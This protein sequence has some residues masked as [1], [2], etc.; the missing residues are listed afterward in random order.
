MDW[1][2]GRREGGRESQAQCPCARRVASGFLLPRCSMREA[3]RACLPHRS[4]LRARG[5]PP[6]VCPPRA[7]LL[8]GRHFSQ[9]QVPPERASLLLGV[10]VGEGGALS[11]AGPAYSDTSVRGPDPSSRS[12]YFLFSLAWF[13]EQIPASVALLALLGF[14]GAFSGTGSAQ[15]WFTESPIC[16]L[17]QLLLLGQ[18]VAAFFHSYSGFLWL[19]SIVFLEREF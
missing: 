19:S 7:P 15:C 16:L 13:S 14:P 10:L 9:Q 3:G 4:R 8:G 1:L 18:R 12:C 5:K 11:S 2:T 17:E 6:P